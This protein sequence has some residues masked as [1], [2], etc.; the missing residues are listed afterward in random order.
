MVVG[1]T[2]AN[3]QRS[4]P[5]HPAQHNQ[6]R[7]GDF[8]NDHPLPPF[9]LPMASWHVLLWLLALPST[10]CVPPRFKMHP[11]NERVL[12]KFFPPTWRLPVSDEDLRI[13]RKWKTYVYDL[14]RRFNRDVV[15]DLFNYR[16]DRTCIR[17]PCNFS[18]L[19][20]SKGFPNQYPDDLAEVPILMK[21][22]AVLDI[23]RDPDTADLFLVP[24]LPA[25]R[26]WLWGCRSGCPKLERW[27]KDLR[28]NVTWI[29][30]TRKHL[31]LVT[32][33]AARY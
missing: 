9:Q 6:R 31:F 5:E 32:Q 18:F 4:P 13:G 20:T 10:S 15:T 21:L 26:G 22:L 33:G 27:L 17:T 24:A 23:T 1:A 2:R 7:F 29:N 3:R 11:Q 14:P 16:V 8:L 19:K 12:A 28:G 25:T 30:T